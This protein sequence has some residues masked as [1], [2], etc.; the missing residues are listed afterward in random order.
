MKKIH[1]T[2]TQVKAAQKLVERKT[3]AGEDVRTGIAKIAQA[4][5]RS[6]SASK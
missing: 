6:D 2:R 4:G 3:A 1:V 5:K